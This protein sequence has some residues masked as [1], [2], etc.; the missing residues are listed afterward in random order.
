MGS[1]CHVCEEVLASRAALAAHSE[2][3]DPSD[4]VVCRAC[5]AESV[6]LR[7]HRAHLRRCFPCRVCLR[8][9]TSEARRDEHVCLVSN[10]QP[11]ICAC[12][13]TFVHYD[14][15]VEHTRGT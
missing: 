10:G 1:Q 14:E 8:R 4:R 3:H 9:F 11:L 12:G 15:I 2:L 13:Q 6:T 7:R 5:G